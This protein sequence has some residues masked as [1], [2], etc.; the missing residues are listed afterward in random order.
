MNS[1]SPSDAPDS[2][3]PAEDDPSAWPFIRGFAIGFGLAAF[4]A[5]SIVLAMLNGPQ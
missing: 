2:F 3:L 5:T 4:I 1:D